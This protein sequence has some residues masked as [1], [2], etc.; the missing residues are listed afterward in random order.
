VD[1]IDGR[2]AEIDAELSEE[3][4]RKARLAE[5]ETNLKGLASARAAQESVLEN[6]KKNAAL[7]GRT[8]QTDFHPAGWTRTL[9]HGSCRT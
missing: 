4:T 2:I 3:E 8:T 9:T 7:A 1:E 5:L 6:I